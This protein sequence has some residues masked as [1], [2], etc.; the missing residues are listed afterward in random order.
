MS[1]FE[2]QDS[3]IRFFSSSNLS[4]L[5]MLAFVGPLRDRGPGSRLPSSL[6]GPPDAKDKFEGLRLR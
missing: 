2:K 3:I 5:V 6:A 4:A 1:T